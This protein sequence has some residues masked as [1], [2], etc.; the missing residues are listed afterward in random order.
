MVLS[1]MSGRQKV[2]KK[3]NRQEYSPAVFYKFV[4]FLLDKTL[5]VNIIYIV[6]HEALR[7]CVVQI[8][9]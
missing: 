1:A 6:N 2:H 3:E 4:M 5:F 8:K 9:S 7:K